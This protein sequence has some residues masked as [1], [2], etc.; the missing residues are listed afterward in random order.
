M[1][2]FLNGVI[3]FALRQRVV[4]ATLAACLVASEPGRYSGCPSMCFPI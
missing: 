1:S 4:V 2:Q 3:W